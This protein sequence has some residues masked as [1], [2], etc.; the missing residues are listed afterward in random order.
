MRPDL[1][2]RGTKEVLLRSQVLRGTMGNHRS[3]G[4][5][6]SNNNPNHNTTAPPLTLSAGLK[7]VCGYSERKY[8]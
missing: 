7:T 1:K 2:I 8:S 6:F 4:N 5:T 3:S